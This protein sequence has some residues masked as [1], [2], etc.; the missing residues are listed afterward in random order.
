MLSAEPLK[1]S[2]ACNVSRLRKAKGLSQEQL[3]DMVGVSR[4]HL[5]RIE[6]GV[7]IPKADLLYSLADI[8]GVTTDTLRQVADGQHV[9]S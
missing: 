1:R 5:A 7:Y 3:A 6:T 2:L 8:L 4:V 9:T